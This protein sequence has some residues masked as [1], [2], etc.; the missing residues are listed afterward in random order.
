MALQLKQ[1]SFKAG[2][3]SV[4]Q[5]ISFSVER[6]KRHILIGPSGSGK[7]TI[8]KAI[9]GLEE[10]VTGSITLNGRK[11]LGE[12]TSLIPSEHRHV[13]YLPQ[14][15]ALFP[16][17][18]VAQNLRFASRSEEGVQHWVHTLGLKALLH[19]Y[20]HELS[21]GEAQRTALGRALARSPSVLLLDEPFSSLDPPR[22]SALRKALVDTLDASARPL[23]VVIV[24]HDREDIFELADSV[25]VV[26][27]G[28]IL[29]SGTVDQLYRK[30]SYTLTASLLGDWFRV[31][32][33]LGGDESLFSDVEVAG[34]SERTVIGYRPDQIRRVEQGVSARVSK[35]RPQASFWHVELEV[36]GANLVH[37]IWA[38][39]PEDGTSVHVE[40]TGSL[41][42]MRTLS[43]EENEL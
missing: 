34:S 41:M 13:G 31:P 22:R 20:P 36:A 29:E 14:G 30:P 18:T 5:D 38:E 25:S 27:N 1:L 16:R 40:C 8:L 26:A 4:L 11:L 28:T 35:S 37:A 7:S 10:G 15:F 23:P 19:R 3:T 33:A 9:A 24:T 21:G 32:S 6:G 12:D 42:G 2:A 17:M 43:E 39:R